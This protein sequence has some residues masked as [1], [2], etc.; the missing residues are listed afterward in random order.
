MVLV[1]IKGSEPVPAQRVRDRAA[2]DRLL[3]GADEHRGDRDDEFVEQ[4]LGDQQP[5][6]RRAALAHDRSDSRAARSLQCC[7]QATGV[8]Q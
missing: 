8:G 4:V 5:E 7:A 1:A 6:Q 2:D 3:A